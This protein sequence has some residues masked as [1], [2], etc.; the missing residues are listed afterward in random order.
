MLAA[1]TMSRRREIVSRGRRCGPPRTR[2]RR[3][4]PRSCTGRP[5]ASAR[6]AGRAA[7]A[8]RGAAPRRRRRCRS[9][10]RLRDLRRLPVPGDGTHRDDVR[11]RLGEAA[12][13]GRRSRERRQPRG[14]T[15]GG[16]GTGTMAATGVPRRVTTTSSPASTRSRISVRRCRAS[17]TPTMR[18]I[19]HQSAPH[20][21]KCVEAASRL[22]HSAAG[23]HE[24]A[25][26][27]S[28][29]HLHRQAGRDPARLVRRGRRG[30]DPR[31]S[32]DRD[33]RH[34]PWQGQAHVHP[35][36]RHRRLRH[37]R[38]R[39]EGARHG[40]EARPEDGAV[41]T[42]ATRA[43]SRSGRCASSSSGAR[44]RSSARP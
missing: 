11:D 39:R 6:V 13:G 35:P 26:F 8:A 34:A 43:G 21:R 10:T 20:G 22:L 3:R 27:P 19:M 7:S 18:L 38:Q 25:L 32:R 28:D 33:R 42:P 40:Q 37:R 23:G 14:R 16:T 36:R 2:S 9:R 31:S 12:A 4:S 1:S 29:D 15:S 30:Q 17:V 5:P 24:T 44:P 41:G